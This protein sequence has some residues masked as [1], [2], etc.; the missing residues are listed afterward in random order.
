VF[1]DEEFAVRRNEDLD[2]SVI[3]GRLRYLSFF[4]LLVIAT[5]LGVPSLNL[6]THDS[7]S[8]SARG[9]DP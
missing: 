5:A 2:A 6:V 8:S 1:D 3:S 4:M 7:A 9:G